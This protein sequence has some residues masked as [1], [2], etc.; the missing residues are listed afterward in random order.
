MRFNSHNEAV[1]SISM[2]NNAVVRRKRIRVSM[3]K[4]ERSDRKNGK[5]NYGGLT[6]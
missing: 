6:Q 1:R 5:E 2:L 3:A 4:Y